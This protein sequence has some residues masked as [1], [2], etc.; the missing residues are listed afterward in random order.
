ML[1]TKQRDWTR[2][3]RF[4]DRRKRIARRTE[5]D[6]FEVMIMPTL[7]IFG[8]LGWILLLLTRLLASLP[9]TGMC[10][11][12]VMAAGPTLLVGL[13]ESYRFVRGHHSSA[14]HAGD[15]QS[16]RIQRVPRLSFLTWCD[17]SLQA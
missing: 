1:H 5:R 4:H 14:L 9:G 6:N 12:T 7:D 8:V 11:Y 3:S 2:N 17:E 16:R 10:G 13:M 15:Q